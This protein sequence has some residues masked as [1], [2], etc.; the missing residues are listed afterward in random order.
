MG[1][2][3]MGERGIILGSS[4]YTI[5]GVRAKTIGKKS[6]KIS[7]IHCGIDFTIMQDKAKSTERLKFIASQLNQYRYAYDYLEDTLDGQ[8]QRKKL[9]TLIA[10]LEEEQSIISIHISDVLSQINSDE[11]AVIEV[12]GSITPGTF[13]EICQVGLDVKEDLYRVRVILDSVLEKLV[14]QKLDR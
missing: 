9:K 13:L 8:E 4:I 12:S 10:K 14:I 5:H 1:F 11:K 3:D 6:G 7:R 2:L